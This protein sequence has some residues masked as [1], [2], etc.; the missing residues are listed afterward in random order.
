MWA[1]IILKD[2]CWSEEDVAIGSTL[3]PVIEVA[4]ACAIQ[5]CV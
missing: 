3:S 1:K 4:A 5:F 2:V